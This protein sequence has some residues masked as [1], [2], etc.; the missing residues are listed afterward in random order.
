[1]K[2]EEKFGRDIYRTGDR[3]G[4][5]T[6]TPL[7]DSSMLRTS[8][9][10]RRRSRQYFLWVGQSRCWHDIPQYRASCRQLNMLN[11]KYQFFLTIDK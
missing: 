1:M 2:Q 7:P 8:G 5:P 11:N 10:A 9:K 6:L 3:S 4:A